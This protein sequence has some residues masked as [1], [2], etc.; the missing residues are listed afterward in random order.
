LKTEQN[1]K[2][3]QISKSKQNLKS[4]QISKSKQIS[5]YEQISKSEEKNGK[6]KKH[7]CFKN[8]THSPIFKANALCGARQKASAK[9]GIGIPVCLR[10][11]YHTTA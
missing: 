10:V 4:E 7:I 6:R 3:E 9:R 8:Q 2:S 5:K 1:L 11:L